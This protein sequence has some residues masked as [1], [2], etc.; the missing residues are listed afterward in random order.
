MGFSEKLEIIEKIIKTPLFA[1]P[2]YAL[3]KLFFITT[4][5]GS[6]SLW[7]LDFS[8]GEKI[9]L[10][11][12]LSGISDIVPNSPYILYTKDVSKGR[13]LH[14]PFILNIKT[15]EHF[16]IQ[17][18]EPRRIIGLSFDGDK[19]ALSSATGKAI[20]LWVIK[21][22]GEAEKVYEGQQFFYTTGIH[23]DK[24]VGQGV[25]RGNPRSQ[26]LFIYHIDSGEFRIYTPKEGSTNKSPRRQIS[27]FT[28]EKRRAN[29]R[30]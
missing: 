29:S 10:V 28:K 20:D 12:E 24:I 30:S 22:S 11:D 18:I 27:D 4:L 9:K 16:E 1:T 23:R 17:E 21:P 15:M 7:M 13:E 8:S 5:E 2:G 14:K 3:G 6:R 25:L 19:F 26:E